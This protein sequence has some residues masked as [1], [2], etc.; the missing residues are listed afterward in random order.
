MTAALPCAL[1][2][3][4]SETPPVRLVPTPAKPA[5]DVAGL[6]PE[7]AAALVAANASPAVVRAAAVRFA[8]WR[9]SLRHMARW[10]WDEYRKPPPD[11]PTYEHA[12]RAIVA[13]CIVAER[14]G[15]LER[16]W[17]EPTGWRPAR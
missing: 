10:F 12:A 14:D 6:R 3:P 9:D 1:S 16:T 7:L 17:A 11:A 8:A 5:P 15:I 13:G 2:S 4:P